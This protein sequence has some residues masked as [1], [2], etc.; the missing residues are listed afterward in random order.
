M[1]GA[2]SAAFSVQLARSSG[3]EEALYSSIYSLFADDSVP[4]QAIS[5]ITISETKFADRGIGNRNIITGKV[6]KTKGNTLL[7]T[8]IG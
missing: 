1:L 5:L 8:N 3:W 2:P 6:K 7:L 4:I